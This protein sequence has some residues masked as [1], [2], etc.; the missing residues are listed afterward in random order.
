MR[1]LASATSSVADTATNIERRSVVKVTK[2]TV[3]YSETRSFGNHHNVRPSI[4]YE[5]DFNPAKDPI[6]GDTYDLMDIAICQVRQEIDDALEANGYSPVYTDDELYEVFTSEARREVVVII[7]SSLHQSW[8]PFD[9]MKA[10][11]KMRIMAAISLAARLSKEMDYIFSGEGPNNIDDLKD[12]PPD[13]DEDE[14]VP[15]VPE[16]EIPF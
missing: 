14:T 8:P 12:L 10:G 1:G 3:T 13:S 9:Y 4:T 11:K 7:S 15:D 6:I 5:A 2:I 16:D